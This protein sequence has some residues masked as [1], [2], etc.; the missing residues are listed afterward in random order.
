M[1]KNAG[2]DAVPMLFY[3]F[4][5]ASALLG[6]LAAITRSE[7]PRGKSVR[8]LVL[9][10]ALYV[11]QAFCFIQ[12]LQ[13]SNPITASL[14]LYLYPAFVTVGS[15]MFL[16]ER[17][18]LRKSFALLFAFAGSILIMAATG[19]VGSASH[20]G[21]AIAF[22]VGTALSYA[23]YLIVGKKVLEGQPPAGSTLAIF[24]TATIIFGFGTM[25]DGFDIA[26]GPSGWLG[27]AG[28]AVVATV[29]SI[30]GLSAGL[31]W[32]TP[33]EAASLSA[34]EPLVTAIIAV[35][36][37]GIQLRLLHVV[38]GLLVVAA[39]LLLSQKPAEPDPAR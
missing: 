37:M 29:I 12:C 24:L 39:V 4:A 23:C 2:I 27:I 30:G 28:L 10:G 33:V 35:T 3:R 7:M 11:C 15:V 22:G 32:I 36:A 16:H 21:V 1:A 5:L 13:N 38:G 26:S 20:P 9:M 18:T 31:K 8:G 34:I 25:I 19:S 17:M 14:L 6:L